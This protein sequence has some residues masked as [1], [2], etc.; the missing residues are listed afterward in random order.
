M[1]IA[2]M[3]GRNTPGWSFDGGAGEVTQTVDGMLVVSSTIQIHQE[4]AE[5]LD[6]LRRVKLLGRPPDSSSFR[7][8]CIR[9]SGYERDA[10]ARKVLDRAVSFEFKSVPLQDALESISTQIQFPVIIDFELRQRMGDELQAPVTLAVSDMPLR[11]G[12][13]RLL[14]D[15]G[16]TSLALNEVIV[17]SSDP[18]ASWGIFPV[19]DLFPDVDLDMI[20][21]QFDA[22]LD[23]VMTHTCS[24]KP[25]WLDDGG[26]CDLRQLP[27]ASALCT[28]LTDS[29]FVEVSELLSE[30]RRVRHAQPAPVS[31]R[32]KI[33]RRAYHL[34]KGSVQSLEV[35]AEQLQH[36]VMVNDWP[37]PPV[38][39]EDRLLIEQPVVGHFRI[40]SALSERQIPLVPDQP[41]SR[42]G[43]G[44]ASREYGHSW[45]PTYT[46]SETK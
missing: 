42:R 26:L 16:A 3:I 11:S 34:A 21:V 36:A 43:R 37:S 5:F 2:A 1:A 25:G 20:D 22:M 10:M 32:K 44:V 29:G 17:I 31:P 4:I 27:R 41:L 33:E 40:E 19:A 46:P 23:L 7:P 28:L 14:G 30:V 39:A 9:G 24:P 35:I 18:T 15:L 45:G 12:L 8:D 38:L 6:A 13:K